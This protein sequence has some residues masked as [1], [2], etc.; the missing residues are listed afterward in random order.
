MN[1]FCYK[2]ENSQNL[3]NANTINLTK[4][5]KYVSLANQTCVAPQAWKQIIN[6]NNGH[7]I[8]P[9]I[10]INK[11]KWLKITMAHARARAREQEKKNGIKSMKECGCVCVC[12][13]VR[14]GSLLK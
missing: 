9:N 11:A 7:K 12:N 1:F 14:R 4:A 10:L 2:N 8:P 13:A 5:N 6:G 3:C